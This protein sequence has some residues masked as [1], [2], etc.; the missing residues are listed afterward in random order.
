VNDT[1]RADFVDHPAFAPYLG[2]LAQLRGPGWPG[3][4]R[5]NTLAA[6]ARLCNACDQPLRFVRQSVRCGQREYERSIYAEA[7]VPTREHN[8]HDLFNAL[9]WLTFPRSKTALNAWQ[10]RALQSDA[11][12]SPASDTA[13][14]FDESGLLLVGEDVALVQL[15]REHRWQEALVER[16]AAWSG[17]RAYVIG[18]A[19]LEKLLDPWPAIT[20]K[21]LHLPLPAATPLA[22]LDAELAC[23][24]QGQSVSRPADL[25]PLPVLGIPGWWP[26]NADPAF[27]L[28]RQVFRPV[29]A[30]I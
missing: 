4:E 30:S 21:C 8:W 20:A 11:R 13:T 14:L 15:L 1:W 24:W 10:C 16:R 29:R 6:E 23:A 27:Y 3:L 9:V 5:L 22:D 25:F 28:D 26:A 2:W 19:V 17:L 7:S 18:H 12:R